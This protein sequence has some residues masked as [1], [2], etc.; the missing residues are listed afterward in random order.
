MVKITLPEAYVVDELPQS[1]VFI[2]PDK[3]GRFTYNAQINGNVINIMSSLQINKP[4]YIGDEYKNLRE[5]YTQL[6]AKQNEQ[7]VLKKKQ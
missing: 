7:I 2:L 3:S 4:L 1:K 5:F 6:I